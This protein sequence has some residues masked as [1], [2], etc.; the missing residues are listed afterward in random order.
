MTP[1]A[2]VEAAIA[3]RY[4]L[5]GLLGQSGINTSFPSYIEVTNQATYQADAEGA[6]LTATPIAGLR[7]QFDINQLHRFFTSGQAIEIVC[8]HNPGAT[9]TASDLELKSI[10]DNSGRIRFTM[11]KFY[12]MTSSSTP[13]L[14][15]PP[16]DGGFSSINGTSTASVLQTFATFSVGASTISIR[17]QRGFANPNSIDMYV[18]VTTGS[19]TTGTFAIQWSKQLG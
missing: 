2:A 18:Y 7:Y 16:L 3:K 9:P 1:R 10:T 5:K 8:T 15:A 6:S 12:T 11:D 14:T 19:N 13:T 4:T 17:G